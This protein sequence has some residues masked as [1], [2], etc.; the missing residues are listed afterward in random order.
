[1]YV[2]VIGFGGGAGILFSIWS[3]GCP[4]TYYRY[5][6][7]ELSAVDEIIRLLAGWGGYSLQLIFALVGIMLILGGTG[8]WARRVWSGVVCLVIAA[9]LV[10]GRVTLF[11]IITCDPYAVSE[12]LA[13]WFEYFGAVILGT[14]V[15]ILPI[16]LLSVG[17]HF[18][19][20]QTFPMLRTIYHWLASYVEGGILVLS[21][22]LFGIS[23][24]TALLMCLVFLP[25]VICFVNPEQEITRHI[26][27]QLELVGRTVLVVVTLLL[28]V[29]I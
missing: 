18:Y 19:L 15:F 14:L 24:W 8:R 3:N 23:P 6:P 22:L 7:I 29:L 4:T 27:R 21:L 2:P 5:R 20:R 12:R 11:G 13:P 28:V 17:F 25:L 1:M 16:T 26:K 10:V 9:I